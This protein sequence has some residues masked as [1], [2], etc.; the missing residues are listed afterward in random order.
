MNEVFAFRLRSARKLAGW[1]LREL[2]EQMGQLVS[3]NAI[4]K[5]EDG[6]MMPE[7]SVMLALAEALK[8][9]VAYFSRPVR[10]ELGDI[11]FRKKTSLRVKQIDQIKAQTR[12]LL[13]RYVEVEEILD[14]QTAFNHPLTHQHITNEVDVEQAAETLRESWKIGENPIPNVIEMM[15]EKEVKVLE[16]DASEKFDGL[17]TFVSHIPVT[18]LN[19]NF[20]SERK[21]FTALHEL[22]HLVLKITNEDKK[23]QLCNQFAG[24][25]LISRS[26]LERLLGKR[27]T[28]VPEMGELIPIKEAYGISLQALMRRAYD[29]DII[30]RSVYQQFSRRM[31]TN[32]KEEGLGEFKGQEQAF[33]F[34]QLIFR[35]VSESVITMDKAAA[36]AGMH[37]E[38]F[39][40][41][42]YRNEENETDWSHHPEWSRFSDAYDDDNEPDY[43]FSDIIELNPDYDPR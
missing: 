23:E 11:E 32:R 4:K 7:P 20:P 12:D 18:I 1:S 14:I 30:P 33:R 2:S 35:L 15:E 25:M 34:L 29:L 31:A 16:I 26:E 21:R 42:Y 28:K 43:D 19:G 10:F 22:G 13:E 39:R 5:Y 17:S 36:L 27:R 6:K 38:A 37:V 40:D 9:K 41:A 8:V 3:Y 24:A